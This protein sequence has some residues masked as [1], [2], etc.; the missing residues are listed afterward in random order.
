MPLIKLRILVVFQIPQNS[1]LPIK[2]YLKF[3][4]WEDERDVISALKKLNHEVFLIGLKSDINTLIKAIKDLK[5]NL[6]FNLCETFN[7]QRKHEANITSVCELLNVPYTGASPFALH[8][9]QD[10]AVQKKILSYDKIMTPRFTVIP[11]NR[12]QPLIN[13]IHYPAIVKPLNLEASEGISQKSYVTN[14]NSCYERIKFIQK[15][16][17]S[18][19]IV[20]EYIEGMDAYIAIIGNKTLIIGE[21]VQLVFS[22]YSPKKLPIATYKT[23]WDATYRKKWGIK[24]IVMKKSRFTHKIQKTCE[25][26]YF[27]LKLSGYARFDIRINKKNECFFLEANPNPSIAKNDDFS[28]SAKACGISYNEIIQQIICTSLHEKSS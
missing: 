3:T 24:T 7:Q 13:N 25:N 19:I 2:S 17:K 16:F 11:K 5:P 10:K 9:C 18:D 4:D 23:K 26:I 20:E 21:P 28:K 14:P 22:R 27:K 12:K 15:K 6:V 1:N 8:L